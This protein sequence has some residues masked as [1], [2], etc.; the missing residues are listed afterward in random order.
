MPFPTS[1]V[2]DLRPDLGGSFEEFPLELASQGFIGLQVLPPIDVMRQAAALGKIPVEEMLKN[3]DTK[4]ASGASYRRRNMRFETF[5]YACE[6]NGL[7]EPVDAR[8]A[9][10][11]GDFFDAEMLAAA[12]AR[13]TIAVEMEKR[14][15]TLVINTTTWT[16]STLATTVGT[17]WATIASATPI[18]D[19]LA[20]KRRVFNGTGVW[21][22]TLIISM[23]TFQNL[24]NNAEIIA[25]ISASGA[26]GPVKASD[27]SAQLIAQVMGL[28]QVLVGGAAK[29]TAGDGLA[30]SISEVWGTGYAMV[31]RCAPQGSKDI[32][33]PCIGRIFHYTEDGSSIGG[34]MESYDEPQTRSRI[35]RVRHDTDEVVIYPQMG[36]LLDIVP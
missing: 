12:R 26:G 19:V 14:I 3:V 22:N 24:Q 5:N 25:R 33:T 10:I 9:A 1:A 6:E 18:A 29:N 21:P 7:E 36:H 35:I 8:D 15:A 23:Q 2:T 20:A 16:G 27:I 32:Q 4:R 11:F 28:E 31:C 17:S 34:V 13:H 30:A